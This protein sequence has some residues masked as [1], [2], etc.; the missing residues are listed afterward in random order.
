MIDCLY[1]D[2]CKGKLDQ[3]GKCVEIFETI[4]R[5]VRIEDIDQLIGT[6][7]KW[8]NHSKDIQKN[9]DDN[10]TKAQKKFDNAKKSN[11]EYEKKVDELKKNL[12]ELIE[13]GD[14]GNY[15]GSGKKTKF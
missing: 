13:T 11:F 9:M 5:D 6:L 15:K 7:K 3:K 8:M 12:K 10:S 4:G 14:S 1:A 2:I